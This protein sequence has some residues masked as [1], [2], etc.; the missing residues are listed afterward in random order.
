MLILRCQQA[1]DCR[2]LKLGGEYVKA[3]R[4][5]EIAQGGEGEHRSIKH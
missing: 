1:I 2:H 3:M 5:S 4:V